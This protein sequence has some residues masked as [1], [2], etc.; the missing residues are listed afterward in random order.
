MAFLFTKIK[1]DERTKPAQVN[2]NSVTKKPHYFKKVVRLSYG[3]YLLFF[4]VSRLLNGLVFQL[5]HLPD[6]VTFS[7]TH[8][9]KYICRLMVN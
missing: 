8:N 4:T 7:P 6:D 9:P 1:H 5:S 3:L 2:K